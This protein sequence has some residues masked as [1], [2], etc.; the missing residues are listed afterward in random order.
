MRCS[1]SIKAELPTMA[2]KLNYKALDQVHNGWE[3]QVVY[4]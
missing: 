3:A 2:P 1:Y 4:M